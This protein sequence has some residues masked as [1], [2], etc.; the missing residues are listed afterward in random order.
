MY[1]FQ[2]FINSLVVAMKREHDDAA[3]PWAKERKRSKL[4]QPVLIPLGSGAAAKS[5][6]E[7]GLKIFLLFNNPA[8]H[9]CFKSLGLASFYALLCKL[10]FEIFSTPQEKNKVPE[11]PAKDVLDFLVSFAKKLDDHG[12]PDAEEQAGSTAASSSKPSSATPMPTVDGCKPKAAPPL[13]IPM[14]KAPPQLLLPTA[15]ASPPMAAAMANPVSTSSAGF[16]KGVPLPVE[17]NYNQCKLVVT[18]NEM[19]Q[20]LYGNEQ[21]VSQQDHVVETVWKFSWLQL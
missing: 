6:K 1:H 5:A 18:P 7:S 15:K 4:P 9:Q 17:E 20:F 19:K 12:I 14:Q 8:F 10:F 2:I 3:A 11:P 16:A 21:R 13:Q